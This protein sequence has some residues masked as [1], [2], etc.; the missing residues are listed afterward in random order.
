[1][2][3]WPTIKKNVYL[4]FSERLRRPR[5]L[6]E[7]GLRN[8]RWP[9]IHLLPRPSYGRRQAHLP[10]GSSKKVR[11]VTRQSLL[12]WF[13]FRN[14]HLIWCSRSC[15]CI[16][17]FMLMW[18][19]NCKVSILV[20]SLPTLAFQHICLVIYGILLS[21]SHMADLQLGYSAVYDEMWR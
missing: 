13:G 4:I 2:W 12:L 21:D 7:G 5:R 18:E 16:K 20:T 19:Q 1:M 17:S 9:R 15:H 6:L 3:W 11:R 14:S 10:R 8:H